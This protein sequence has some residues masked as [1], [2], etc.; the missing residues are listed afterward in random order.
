MDLS[1]PIGSVIPS[2]HGAVLAV[3]A[4]TAEQLS[5]RRVA[6]LTDGKVGQWRANEVLGELAEAGIVLR[7]HRPPANLYRLN[8]DHVAAAGITALA[9]QWA[10]LLQRIRDDID[11]WSTP[12]DAACLFGSA[13]RG[14]AGPASDIDV[15]LVRPADV[16]ASEDT[17]RA[18]QAQVDRF[19]QDVRTWS[20][21]TCEVL[22][23]TLAELD[24][25]VA[26]DDRLVRELR[27]DAITLAGQDI[28]SLLRPRVA[29]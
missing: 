26:R 10:T 24:D 13:A 16:A 6:A 19:T 28:R 15:L 9:D 20:G 25:A 1:N 14:A 5:G 29:R 23:L 3:L 11:G 2:A 27:D 7:E 12:P 4:R 17:E 18:W 22:E 21:N 8:R